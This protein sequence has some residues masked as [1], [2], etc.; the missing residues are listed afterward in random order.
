MYLSETEF[1]TIYANRD[2]N[3][4]EKTIQA[5]AELNCCSTDVIHAYLDTYCESYRKDTTIVKPKEVIENSRKKLVEN[6]QDYPIFSRGELTLPWQC[7]LDM[8]KEK[9]I[10]FDTIEHEFS[11]AS[12]F[13]VH[14]LKRAYNTSERNE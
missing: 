7:Y 6:R 14:K 2:R 10:D 4:P 3:R 11:K 8:C 9:N 13:E 5:L 1:C 12:K